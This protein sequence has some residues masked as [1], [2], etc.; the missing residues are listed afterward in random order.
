VIAAVGEE[1]DSRGARHLIPRHSPDFL[2]IGEPSGAANVTVGYKGSLEVALTFEGARAHL[3]AP[4][5][6]TVEAA[7]AV[8][9]EIRGFCASR[10]GASPFTSLTA[11]VHAIHTVQMGGRELVEVRANFRLP[12]SVKTEE[13]LSFLEEG[14]VRYRVI[15]RSEAVEVDP[16]NPVVRALVAGIRGEGGHPTLVRRSGSADMN[17]AVPVWGCPAAAYGPG[18]SHLDHTD[19]ERLELEELRRSFL[20]MTQAFRTLCV[21]TPPEGPPS[22]E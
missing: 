22:A 2:L 7:L 13:V 4:S 14:A 5:A 11:K 19:E 21:R 12:P 20:V 17:L 16:K 1:K 9:P 3:S 6:T 8:I 18:D 10:G 15:D